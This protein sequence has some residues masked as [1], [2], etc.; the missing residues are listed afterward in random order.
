MEGFCYSAESA[1]STL[2]VARAMAKNEHVEN[3]F[4]S[5]DL[6]E[7]A[8]FEMRGCE[9]FAEVA[10]EHA[11][12]DILRKDEIGKAD[13][14]RALDLAALEPTRTTRAGRTLEEG[15][16]I[17]AWIFG[18]FAHGPMTGLTK[19][20]QQHPL[21]AQLLTR[22]FRQEVPGGEFGAVAVLVSV[23]FKPHKDNNAKDFPT[24][25]TT[26]TEY[27]G[28]DLWLEDSNGSELRV[29]CEG[30]DPIAGRCVSLKSGVVQFDGSKWHGTEAFDG[31][32]LVAVAYTPKHHRHWTDD[33]REKLKQ[34]GFPVRRS[35]S[36]SVNCRS[37]TSNIHQ[38]SAAPLEH[39][40]SPASLQHTTSPQHH[41]DTQIPNPKEPR[42]EE[43]SSSGNLKGCSGGDMGLYDF[44][45]VPGDGN[46]DFGVP[47]GS[48]RAAMV[49][50][51]QVMAFLAEGSDVD[52]SEPHHASGWDQAA[53]EAS[54]REL[55]KKCH[56]GLY[57]VSCPQC[58]GSNATS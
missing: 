36:T 46:D 10:Y 58:R 56:A 39:I 37:D 33:T 32:R 29:I 16:K 30:K 25:I 49:S 31:R 17:R 27:S 14:Q 40:T 12:K 1:I 26:F 11:I 7:A 9:M 15:G 48:N 38:Q 19:A 21:L 51:R 43:A 6:L 42:T 57:D 2:G 53:Y 47:E 35:Q 55:A 5:Q 3:L 54:L 50:A 13:V 44:G 34:L 4:I 18:G 24:Y 8:E 20:T 52:E 23:A 28:G 22:Y 45:V 41:P